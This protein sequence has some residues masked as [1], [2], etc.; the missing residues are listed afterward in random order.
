MMST[1]STNAYTFYFFGFLSHN[2]DGECLIVYVVLKS[3]FVHFSLRITFILK[4]IVIFRNTTTFCQKVTIAWSCNAYQISRLFD[5]HLQ[6]SSNFQVLNSIL[7]GIS[8]IELLPTTPALEWSS[9]SKQ[10]M[11]TDKF[12]IKLCLFVPRQRNSTSQHLPM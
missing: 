9:W 1:I 2:Y 12:G 6:P 3:N 8:V 7:K 5:K 10:Q 4:K 11:W